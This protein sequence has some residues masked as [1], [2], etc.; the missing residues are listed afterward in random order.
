VVP[1]SSAQT[2]WQLRN[3]APF[4]A[5]SDE[6]ERKGRYTYRAVVQLNSTQA[7]ADLYDA[8]AEEAL[9]F[10]DGISVKACSFRDE[11]KPWSLQGVAP[12]STKVWASGCC[13]LQTAPGQFEYV[14]AQ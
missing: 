8:D 11:G 6:I 13:M 2:I 5:V 12:T 14:N 3:R 4:A 1:R 10:D 9:L 7:I